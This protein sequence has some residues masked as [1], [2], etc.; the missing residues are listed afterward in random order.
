VTAPIAAPGIIHGVVFDMD[1]TLYPEIQFVHGGLAAAAAAAGERFGFAPEDLL[2]RMNDALQDDLA[3]FGRARTVFNTALRGLGIVDDPETIAWLVS[4]Y[5]D[6]EP[7]LEPYPDVRPT[8]RL[9]APLVTLALI[10]DGPA[11]V[12]RAKYEGLRLSEFFTAVLFTDE[13][14]PGAGKP[15]PTAFRLVEEMTGLRGAALAYVGDNPAKD[16]V[17]ARRLGWKT[18]RLRRPDGLHATADAEPGLGADAEAVSLGELPRL[19]GVSGVR[20]SP[21]RGV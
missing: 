14:G 20:T 11:T 16:F 4:V 19:L 12:Q 13:C 6:H 3:E 10:T 2:T 15:S 18:I 9:L 8:L 1:D 17:G 21:A 7:K 5:R